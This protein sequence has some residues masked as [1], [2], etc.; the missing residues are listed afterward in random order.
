MSDRTSDYVG[1]GQ[2]LHRDGRSRPDNHSRRCMGVRVVG[3]TD[4]CTP[5]TRLKGPYDVLR[6]RTSETSVHRWTVREESKGRTEGHRRRSSLSTEG[7]REE[8]TREVG[9][10]VPSTSAPEG[11]TGTVY[12]RTK[13]GAEVFRGISS[14]FLRRGKGG[15][16]SRGVLSR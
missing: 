2:N 3:P 16:R 13:E 7:K 9:R 12:G 1:D 14:S 10:G 6:G 15:T 11:S 5:G 8:G 4:P